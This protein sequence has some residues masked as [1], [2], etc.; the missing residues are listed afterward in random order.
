M[1]GSIAAKRAISTEGHRPAASG[2]SCDRRDRVQGHRRFWQIGS[3]ARAGL[4]DV[5]LDLP[6]IV[7]FFDARKGRRGAAAYQ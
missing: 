6:V 3:S 1:V 5:S 2:A 7:E 4:L